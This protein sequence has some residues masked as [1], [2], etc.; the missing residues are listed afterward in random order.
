MQMSSVCI[1][2]GLASVT[3]IRW[4]CC[5]AL[6]SCRPYARNPLQ[7]LERR[8]LAEIGARITSETGLRFAEVKLDDRLTSVNG[9]IVAQN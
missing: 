2:S 4:A 8:E 3:S 1:R 6:I 5:P 7:T 9:K